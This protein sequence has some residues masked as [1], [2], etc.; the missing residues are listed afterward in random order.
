[1][2]DRRQAARQDRSVTAPN[3]SE[4]PDV[5]AAVALPRDRASTASKPDLLDIS[6]FG[7]RVE[8]P[9]ASSPDSIVWL[10]LPDAEPQMA[11]VVWS[12]HAASGCVFLDMLPADLFRRTLRQGSVEATV[13]AG[14]WVTRAAG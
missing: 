12:D 4:T 5:R 6:R 10:K 2:G 11:R 1:M 7:F 3:A 14:P 13:I 8:V 9:T